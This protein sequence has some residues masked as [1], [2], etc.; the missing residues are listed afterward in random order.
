MQLYVHHYGAGF[1]FILGSGAELRGSFM[2]KTLPL[3][4][5]MLVN[6]TEVASF[7]KRMTNIQLINTRAACPE[8]SESCVCTHHMRS[9]V[10]TRH[11]RLP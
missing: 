9:R 5:A 4:Y 6:G 11:M 8:Q 2:R 1:E 3:P 10:C 7:A